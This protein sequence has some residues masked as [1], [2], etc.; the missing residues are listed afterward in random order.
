MHRVHRELLLPPG[1]QLVQ[2]SRTLLDWGVHRAAGLDIA[3]TDSAQ[4][5]ATVVLGLRLGP[6]WAVAPCRVVELIDEPD[7]VGF[8]YATL[9]GHP[10]EGVERFA[11]A[12]TDGA[13][14]F[15]VDAV[16]RPNLWL[17]RLAPFVARRIQARIT[18]RYLRAVAALDALA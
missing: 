11:F 15:E 5:G 3:A 8:S 13:V 14:R 10:E 6:A 16:S 17:S 7:R 2:P 12:R 9:P 1:T 4:V 18:D